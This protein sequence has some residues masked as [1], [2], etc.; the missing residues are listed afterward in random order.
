MPEK[1]S[2]PTRVHAVLL[3]P[4]A[5]HLWVLDDGACGSRP[6]KEV[7]N[8]TIGLAG[9]MLDNELAKHAKIALVLAWERKMLDEAVIRVDEPWSTMVV[10]ISYV[11]TGV[12]D[13]ASLIEATEDIGTIVLLDEDLREVAR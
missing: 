11:L 9:L 1:N 3:I 13:G 5:E 10:A 12:D 2:T 4:N 7:W 8:P 6:P